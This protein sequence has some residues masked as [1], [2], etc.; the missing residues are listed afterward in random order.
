MSVI[1]PEKAEVKEPVKQTRTNKKKGVWTVIGIIAAVLLVVGVAGGSYL[2]HL[3]NTSPEFCATCHIMD[4]NVT[5]YLTS[6]DLDNLHQQANVGC[7]DCHDYPIPAEI[8]SGF[9]FIFGNYTVDE[10]GD[11]LQV[12]YDDDMCLHCHISPEFVATAT[13]FLSKN[14]HNSHNGMMSCKT[15]HVS[16]GAQIDYCAQCHDN[17]NQRMVGDDRVPRGTIR[18]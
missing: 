12:T 17:G 4:R 8:R 14:P 7:K 11:L 18:K 13:D 9:N 6:T 2:V 10:N 15:C 1:E 3:S 5:S 16:H